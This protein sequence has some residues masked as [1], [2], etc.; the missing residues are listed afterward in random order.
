GRGLSS[1]AASSCPAARVWPPVVMRPP[2]TRS[3]VPSFSTRALKLP[4][5]VCGV[6]CGVLTDRG[7]CCSATC[8][9]TSP[10]SSAI[11]RCAPNLGAGTGRDEEDAAVGQ[12]DTPAFLR[13]G[14]D[15]GADLHRLDLGYLRQWLAREQPRLRGMH[16]QRNQ[17][18][19]AE[20]RQQDAHTHERSSVGG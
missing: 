16:R 13:A 1:W 3:R 17:E 10:A 19:D 6:R 20:Q 9:N 2:V 15:L 12:H 14:A 11:S 5:L 8:T 4:R 7:S 18:R